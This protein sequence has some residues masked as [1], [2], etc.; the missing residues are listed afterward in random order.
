MMA[1]V[2]IGEGKNWRE[3]GKADRV[4]ARQLQAIADELTES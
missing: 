2:S 1:M 4:N 3:M